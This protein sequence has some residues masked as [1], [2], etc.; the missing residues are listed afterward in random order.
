MANV[1]RVYMNTGEVIARRLD[2]LVFQTSSS[3]LY[4]VPWTDI[5]ALAPR[6]TKACRSA[7]DLAI[8]CQGIAS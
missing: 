5:S 3:R 2:D 8:L 4:L 6:L 1:V 7:Y